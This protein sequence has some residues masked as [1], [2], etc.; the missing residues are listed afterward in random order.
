MTALVL[1]AADELAGLHDEPAWLRAKRR[2]AF[3]V[4]ERLPLP[5]RTE[6]EWRRTSLKGLD[7]DAFQAFE[8]AGASAPATPIAD[9][10][11]VLRQSGSEPGKVEIDPELS[12][13][14][15]LFVPLSQAA[16]EYPE[17]VQKHLFQEVRPDRDKLAALHAALFS[18]GT[19]LYVPDGVSIA[20]PFV[21]QFWSSTGGA[22]VLP[23]TLIIAGRGSSFN[24]VDEFLSPDLEQPSLTSGSAEIFA[25]EASNVGYVA[26]Q[27]WGNHA[28]QFADER[29]R[30]E[31]DSTVRMVHA[32]L[33]ARFSKNRVEASLNGPGARAELKALYF[34]TGQQFFDFHTLQQHVVGHSTSDLLFKGALREQAQSVYAGLIRIEVGASGSDAYQANRNL[35][36]SNQA[37]ANSIPMLE[38]MNNDVRCTHGATV[39]PV[40]PEHLFYLESRGI[41]PMVAQ[42]MVVHGFF[43]QVLERIPV[44]QAREL[45]EQELED[46]IGF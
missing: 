18:G 42:R 9:T 15:V 45:V 33:G 20:K 25:G 43:G 26:L 23:H 22:L 32:G 29:A 46:R 24:H 27:R 1:S 31:K 21:S 40:D 19:F 13:A 36:L 8:A 4:Y 10:A 3:A 17:L 37:K 16:R 38:I 35:L 2:Q 28:W 12:R 41:P 39:G 34:G 44:Q 5:Q 7:L 30:L 14:G 6:E 11:G